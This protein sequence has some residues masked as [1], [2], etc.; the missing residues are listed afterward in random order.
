MGGLDL[1]M[2]LTSDAIKE[3]AAR[4]QTL[5]NRGIYTLLCKVILGWTTDLPWLNLEEWSL[6]Q[7]LLTPSWIILPAIT[8]HQDILKVGLMHGLTSNHNFVGTKIMRATVYKNHYRNDKS[9]Y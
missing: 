6:I 8:L 5:I 1:I 4:V 3:R 9:E 7:T 2:Y